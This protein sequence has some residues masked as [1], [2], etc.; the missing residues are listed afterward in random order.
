MLLFE[1]VIRPRVGTAE[2]SD[3]QADH[4]DEENPVIVAG[5]G[6]FGNIVG[7]LLR[8]NG[9]GATVLDNDSDRV[10]I[11]RRL[12]LKVFYGD[13]TRHD[14][15]EAAG[16]GDARLI[17]LALDNQEKNLEL[18]H[19]VRKHFPN[20]TILARAIDRPDAYA[21]LDAGVEHVYRETF[22]SSL[23]MGVEALRLLG[24]R[25]YQA[26]RAARTFRRHDDDALDELRAVR[27]DR[28]AYLSAARDA[29]PIWSE[30]SWPTSP[31]RRRPRRAGTPSPS[32]RTCGPA[33]SPPR[34]TEE[35]R[36][37]DMLRADG[38]A[39][40]GSEGG[41]RRRGPLLLGGERPALP[42]LPRPRVGLSRR[43]RPA[44]VREDLP[45]GLP[46][47]P[48]LADH[49]PEA[50][51]LPQRVRRLRLPRRGPLPASETSTA[52]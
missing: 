25:G 49:P 14:L 48:E 18:V 6:R 50:R 52:C 3:R 12:D 29:S 2:K 24:R 40:G 11:L 7:R 17:V 46:V 27:Q 32:A 35:P 36:T 26:E 30:P 43:R 5:F 13:A 51:Q 20:L 21:L 4:I 22:D 34:T 33:P 28:S 45:R 1:R 37:C 23:R 47:G 39:G 38:T 42:A 31:R 41:R 10:D 16:A 19:T 8:A 9:I 44:A 15:L